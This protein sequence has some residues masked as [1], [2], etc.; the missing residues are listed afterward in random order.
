MINIDKYNDVEYIEIPTNEECMVTAVKIGEILEEPPSRIRK[1]A[2]YHEDN[3]Y[4]KKVNGRFAY[5]QKSIDQFKFIKDLKL[6]KNMT[7]EQIKQHMHKHGMQYS[8]YDGGLI[9]PKD[10]FGYEA[11]SSAISQKTE[12]QLKEFLVKFVEYQ[13]HNN[14]ELIKSITS[15]V[16]QTVQDQIEESMSEIEKEL[17]LQKESNKQLSQQLSDVQQELSLTKETNQKQLELQSQ[18]IQ[19]NLDNM[20]NKIIEDNIKVM[21]ET[22]NEFKCI[23]LEQLKNQQPKSFIDRLFHLKK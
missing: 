20:S 2:E 8:K 19:T 16:E 17:E 18:Q 4:V 14:K 9:D 10:P 23:T 3:L 12:N 15:E 6:N 7:H 1:W 22:V 21:N 5:T 13:D 11:L